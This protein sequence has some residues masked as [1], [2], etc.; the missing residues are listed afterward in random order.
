MDNPV[1]YDFV[2]K[3]VGRLLLESQF[4]LQQYQQK[5]GELNQKLAVEQQKRVEV[6]HGVRGT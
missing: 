2:C 4:Q 3:A 5:I 1:P 6:E